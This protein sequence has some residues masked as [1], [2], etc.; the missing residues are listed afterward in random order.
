MPVSAP[1]FK[2]T[3]EVISSTSLILSHADWEWL[4]R[5]QRRS[6]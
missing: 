3:G 2:T 5:R 1:V 4:R 6:G